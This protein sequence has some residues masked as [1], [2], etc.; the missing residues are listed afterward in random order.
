VNG[1]WLSVDGLWL[2]VDGLWLSVDGL[3]LSV[4]GLRCVACNKLHDILCMSQAHAA[5]LLSTF[6][7]FRMQLGNS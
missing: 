3:W 6:I 2:S 1:L 4:N 7:V 5:P